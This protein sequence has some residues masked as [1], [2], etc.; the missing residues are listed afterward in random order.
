ME[1]LQEL[2]QS[3]PEKMI[4]YAEKLHEGIESLGLIDGKSTDFDIAILESFLEK[5][6][7]SF[8]WEFGGYSRAPKFMMPTN[9]Q[10]L[11]Q[12]GHL[13][14]N[15]KLLEYVDLTLTKMAYGG[16]FDT[17]DGGFS[18]YSVDVKWHVPHFEKMAYIIV[19]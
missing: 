19:F 6:Q 5:W 13:T 17:V 3:N 7:K 18:R 4:E 2:Y 8:D 11:L 14:K 12:Y 1:Q 10:F 15:E 9:Y 16:I